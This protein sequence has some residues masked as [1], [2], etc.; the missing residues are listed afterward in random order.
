[1]LQVRFLAGAQI[2]IPCKEYFYLC[3]RETGNFVQESKILNVSHD[4]RE[5]RFERCT[6]HVMEDSWRELN[7]NIERAMLS[8]GPSV[9]LKFSM[10]F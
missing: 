2:K 9:T 5:V 7:I 1:M 3:E 8:V 6:V 10:L 4:L